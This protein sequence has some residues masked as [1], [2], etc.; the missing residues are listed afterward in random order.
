MVPKNVTCF[1]FASLACKALPLP[2]RGGTSTGRGAM[3]MAPAVRSSPRWHLGSGGA[4][5]EPDL[6][7][8]TAGVGGAGEVLSIANPVARARRLE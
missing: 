1:S 4:A 3:A 7:W 6:T 5:S 2:K 8:G